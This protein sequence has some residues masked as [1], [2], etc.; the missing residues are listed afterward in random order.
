MMRPKSS[1]F[2]PKRLLYIAVGVLLAYLLLWVGVLLQNK[3]DHDRQI[4]LARLRLAQTEKLSKEEQAILKAQ[5]YLNDS[6]TLV[7]PSDRLFL[8]YLQRKFGL[9][10]K[11][12]VAGP[13]FDLSEDPRTYP[14]EIHFLARIA[15][16][17]RL[18]TVAPKS[19]PEGAVLTNIYS[20]NCDRMPL[21]DN[22][23][24]TIEQNFKTGGYYLAHDALALAFM[25]DNGCAVPAN[26][27]DLPARVIAGMVNL[28]ADSNTKA[29]LRYETIAFLQLSG[30]RDQVR[31]E[32][33]NQLI[34]EQ[35]DDGS[36]SE[37]AKDNKSSDHATLLALWSLLEYSRPDTPNQ[38]LI[39]RP[40]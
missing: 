20:A 39:R 15:Y 34:S 38:P 19:I 2:K 12:G 11:L 4:R 14:E 36:W 31:P 29:D 27:S 16:P 30:Q 7:T 13:S 28:A 37:E 1:F 33:I 6:I 18:V 10:T 23:W 5:R 35:Q 22:Y 26:E 8:D 9:D 32:W 3:A 25:K 24:Q 21:P 40:S 17:D